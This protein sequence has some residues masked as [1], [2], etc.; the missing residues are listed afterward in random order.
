MPVACQAPGSTVGSTKVWDKLTDGSYIS[1]LYISTPSNTSY[2][3]PVARCR[4]PYQV[5][6]ISGVNQRT[7]PGTSHS[8][9]GQLAS[10]SLAWVT[11]QQAGSK[12]GTTR[13]WDKISYR[14]WVTDYYVATP[15]LTTYSQPAPR[16]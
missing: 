14:H 4:Y 5:T 3:A 1:D 2:S 9:N 6:A 16:C 8:P 12:V 13:I 10:G 15:S 7:G 11:C